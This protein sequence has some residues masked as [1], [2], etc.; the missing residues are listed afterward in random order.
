MGYS[1][2]LSEL[3]KKNLCDIRR[4][5]SSW[6]FYSIAS[7]LTRWPELSTIARKIWS[8]VCYSFITTAAAAL[9]PYPCYGILRYV[10]VHLFKRLIV[11]Y[12]I[13]LDSAWWTNWLLCLGIHRGTTFALDLLRLILTY[14]F[15]ITIGI[16]NDWKLVILNLLKDSAK[17]LLRLLEV[18]QVLNRP[19]II[20]LMPILSRVWGGLIVSAALLLRAQDVGVRGILLVALCVKLIINTCNYSCDRRIWGAPLVV[21]SAYVIILWLIKSGS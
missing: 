5:I 7:D 20:L 6:K 4:F 2:G 15:D 9:Q 13:V 18:P 14:Q 1:C 11:Y 17:L 10:F 19:I 12:R 21:P 8:I 16:F 3:W